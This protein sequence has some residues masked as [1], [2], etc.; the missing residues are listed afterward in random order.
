MMPGSLFTLT[1]ATALVTGGAGI[2]GSCISEA[3]AEAGAHVIIASRDLDSCERMAAALT[4]AGYNASADHYDQADENSVLAMRDRLQSRFQ[5][6]DVLVN[7]SVARPMRRYEDPLQA[8]RDSMDVNAAGL[9]AV[10]RAFLE[11]MIH[12]GA[13]SIINV[14][15]IQSVAAPDFRNYEGTSMSTPPDYH[16]HKHGLIGL[17]RY[18]AALAGPRG[19][20]VNAIS[21]GGAETSETSATFRENYCRR[22]FLGRMARP[23]D[24][25]G[26]VV[27][28]ASAASAYITGQ[29]I[30][31][32]GGYTC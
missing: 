30:V 25:K 1:G 26:A 32:D 3:L 19:V 21:P 6:I 15:S 9:F 20:R 29:N 17:T 31:I 12:T 5:K 2:Y 28:L 22:V 14:G 11:I 24:I 8:W 27:F 10:S 16:F 23:E 13:G 18:L 7:N 4:A